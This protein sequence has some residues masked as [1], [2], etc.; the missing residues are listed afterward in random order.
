MQKIISSFLLLLSLFLLLLTLADSS[1]EFLDSLPPFCSPSPASAIEESKLTGADFS[2]PKQKSAPGQMYAKAY[3]LLDAATDR[4]LIGE[5]ENEQLPM[6]ST[7]KIMTCIIALE[8]GKLN[9]KVEVSSHAA[10]MPDVQL[11]MQSGDSFYLKDLLYSLMLESHNDTAVAIAE[12]IGGSVEGFAA[13]MNEKAAEL[14]CTNTRFVT[15]NGLDAEGHYTTA[16][17]LCLIASYAI[18]NEDFLKIIQTP[19]H[20]FSNCKGTRSYFVYNRDAFLTSYSGAIGIKTG[21]TGKA[22]YCF[23]GAA[24]RNGKTFITSVLACGWPPNKTYK[25]ADTR[26]L[27]DYG[28]QNFEMITLKR[29]KISTTLPVI[30]GIKNSISIRPTSAKSISLMLCEKDEITIKYNLPTILKAPI[31]KGDILGYEEYYLNGELLSQSPI[32]ADE[33]IKERDLSYYGQI[34]KNL[35]FQNIHSPNKSKTTSTAS[36]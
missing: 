34:V 33:T 8:N 11:N 32:I 30:K 14:G 27:M 16:R 29:K 18:Q 13:L 7:T 15:P 10:S 24:K 36:S 17:E 21:F 5:K 22:G 1:R 31:R 6:A 25:W 35:F 2:L 26:K 20:Q 23:C 3:C 12:H 9:S 28:F 4:V 19:S